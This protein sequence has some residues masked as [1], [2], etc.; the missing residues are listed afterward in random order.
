MGQAAAFT[1]NRF[2]RFPFAIADFGFK[3]HLCAEP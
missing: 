1:R 2:H 3:I